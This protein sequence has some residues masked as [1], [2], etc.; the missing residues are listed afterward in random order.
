LK[1]IAP[2]CGFHWRDDDPGGLQSEIW[3]EMMLAGDELMRERLLQYNEDDVAAQRAIRT[4]IRA[5]DNG[6]GPGSSIPSVR[7]WRP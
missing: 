7:T 4:W 2:L 3:Y 6:N 5:N 1:A